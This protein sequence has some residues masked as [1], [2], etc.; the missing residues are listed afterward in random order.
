[1]NHNLKDILPEWL[2]QP[3][4]KSWLSVW[5]AQTSSLVEMSIKCTEIKIRQ[6]WNPQLAHG[7][8][9]LFTI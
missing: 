3:G 8:T 6:I 2:L 4:S 9:S 5:T 1:M 7:Q